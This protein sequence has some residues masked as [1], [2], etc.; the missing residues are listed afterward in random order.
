MTKAARRLSGLI[1]CAACGALSSSCV[2]K[3]A[4]Q[5]HERPLQSSAF[6]ADGQSARPAVSGTVPSGYTRNNARVGPPTSFDPNAQELPFPLTREVLE[7]GRERFDIYC[8]VCH[9]RTGEGD[10]MI[11]RRGFSRPPSYHTERLRQAPLGHFFDVMTNGYGAMPRY[12]AQI[13]ANDR[14]AIAA[15]IRALQLSRDATLED[16]PADKRQEL[17]GGAQTKPSEGG[18]TR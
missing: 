17:D 6:F 3:M 18:R 14:W 7:R 16:V 9:A 1:L 2:Q 4:S 11:V 10:G 15:Y 8:A 13:S 5:P 12:D